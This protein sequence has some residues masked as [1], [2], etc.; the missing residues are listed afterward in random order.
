MPASSP[1]SA[2]R[3]RQVSVRALARRTLLDNK[4]AKRRSSTPESKEP[5]PKRVASCGMK[6]G[7]VI[8]RVP[9]LSSML[10]IVR[11]RAPMKAAGATS[12]QLRIPPPYM[13]AGSRTRH[14][15]KGSRITHEPKHASRQCITA[16]ST[17]RAGANESS[18]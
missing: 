6:P 13:R 7:S 4:T 3:P 14:D 5:S 10:G 16:A 8:P 9:A 15:A 12:A 18:G 1:T 11:Q 2:R 17:T